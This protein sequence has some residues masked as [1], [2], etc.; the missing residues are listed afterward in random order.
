MDQPARQILFA[1]DFSDSAEAAF[2]VAVDYARILHARLHLIHVFAASEVEVTRLLPTRPARQAP[3]LRSPWPAWVAS[4]RLLGSVAERVVRG[5][6]CPVLVVPSRRLATAPA[7]CATFS[8]TADA[9]EPEATVTRPCLVCATPT[10]DLI[11]E[12]CRARIR[13]EALEHKQRAERPGRR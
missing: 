8:V 4:R 2:G 10:R 12:G 6:R 7:P 9:E 1:T 11:C 5:A 3:M 13:G